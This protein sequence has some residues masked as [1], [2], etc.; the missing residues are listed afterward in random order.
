MKKMNEKQTQI[1]AMR[2]DTA[3]VASNI[4]KNTFDAREMLRGKDSHESSPRIKSA[5]GQ[6][7]LHV[8]SD[9]NKP[10]SFNDIEKQKY[11]EGILLVASIL[12][13]ENFEAESGTNED[14]KVVLSLVSGKINM[15]QGMSSILDD[16]HDYGHGKKSR[17]QSDAV[18]FLAEF[19]H[20]LRNLIEQYDVEF[21]QDPQAENKL[22]NMLKMFS[23]GSGINESTVRTL[24][25]GGRHEYMVQR[26]LEKVDGVK[27]IYDLEKEGVT[28]D[29][30]SLDAFSGI[31]I[32][33][34]INGG[35]YGIDVKSSERAAE[36]ANSKLISLG[37]SPNAMWSGIK[38]NDFSG[39]LVPFAQGAKNTDECIEKFAQ[40]T[41]I[42]QRIR[43][44]YEAGALKTV[45]ANKT[46]A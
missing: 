13:A 18:M 25:K 45:Y 12:A 29:A 11:N 5:I 34:K 21:G 40:T 17:E 22:V 6:A 2:K 7:A 37:K 3:E 35:L 15:V 44:M 20:D 8:G 33:F 42:A 36:E 1:N 46:H 27:I 31:D 24:I 14:L 39:A 9:I 38:E 41:H 4:S 19:N 10:E 28:T 32:I 30:I 23:I 43:E 26:M 16:Y